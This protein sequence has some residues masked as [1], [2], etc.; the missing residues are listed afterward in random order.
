MACK[1]FNRSSGWSSKWGRRE[2]TN[3]R[4]VYNPP[5]VKNLIP[6]VARYGRTKSFGR[7][8]LAIT[9]SYLD[10]FFSASNFFFFFKR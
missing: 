6:R 4:G 9:F 8:S 10:F 1:I 7:F 2:F 5:L 3:F